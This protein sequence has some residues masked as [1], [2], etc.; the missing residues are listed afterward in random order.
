VHY[1]DEIIQPNAQR[2]EIYQDYYTLYKEAIRNAQ[3][4]LNKL[5]ALDRSSS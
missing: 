2:H 3:Q 4:T 1:R 5:T